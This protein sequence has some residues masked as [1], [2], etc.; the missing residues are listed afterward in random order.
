MWDASHITSISNDIKS[1]PRQSS[2]TR[3]SCQ[4]SIIE[5]VQLCNSVCRFEACCWQTVLT[6]R[7]PRL[8]TAQNKRTLV[9]FILSNSVKMVVNL[10]RN[11]LSG[12]QMQR[13]PCIKADLRYIV[14]YIVENECSSWLLYSTQC[15]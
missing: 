4:H 8:T 10:P 15:V 11:N 5:V 2:D 12:C 3:T 6:R 7:T 14:K 1:A 13:I 9:S